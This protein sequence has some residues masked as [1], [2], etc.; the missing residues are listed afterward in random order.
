[1]RRPMANTRV[2]DELPAK[3]SMARAGLPAAIPAWRR[4]QAMHRLTTT[5]AVRR[6]LHIGAVTHHPI[7]EY[8]WL[9]NHLI[10]WTRIR[11]DTLVC[12]GNVY[13]SR[14]NAAEMMANGRS[15]GPTRNGKE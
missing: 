7:E 10:Q 2:T 15:I 5:A 13:T 1:M 4:M 14:Q 11:D 3:R 9:G 8:P 6:D 12:V